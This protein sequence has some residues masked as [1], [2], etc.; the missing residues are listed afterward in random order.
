MLSVLD[1]AALIV[2]APG[3]R[4]CSRCPKPHVASAATLCS[5]AWCTLSPRKR[6]VQVFC[7]SHCW[8]S[9]SLCAAVIS[10][11]AVCFSI[12]G[13][14]A[15]SESS[16]R[17]LSECQIQCIYA[18]PI[19]SNTAVPNCH[20]SRSYAES[21]RE[22]YCANK[23]DALSGRLAPVP[24]SVVAHPGSFIMQHVS[25]PKPSLGLHPPQ[26]RDCRQGAV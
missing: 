18:H 26:A 24:T 16:G 13:H 4:S 10:V 14:T 25:A 9:I 20:N 22:V 11:N 19:V 23:N 17:F 6:P 21:G 5:I 15:S 7:D 1:G 12:H 2:L 8:L 3:G